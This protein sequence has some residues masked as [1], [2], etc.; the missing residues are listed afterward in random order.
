[1]KKVVKV[2][3][4]RNTFD[5]VSK[6]EPAIW[7]VCHLTNVLRSRKV[8][9]IAHDGIDGFG[10]DQDGLQIVITG[11]SSASKL[12]G[13]SDAGLNVPVEAES[14]GIANTN[15]TLNSVPTVFAVGSDVRGLVYAVLELADIAK[16]AEDPVEA[17]QS[18]QSI[19]EKPT[20]PVRRITRL[21]TS[22][23]E[24]KPWFYDPQF[25]DEYLTEL[26]T[27]RFNQFTFSVG[28]G[29]DY[30]IDRV[31]LDTYFCF[32][33]PFV[34]SVPGYSVEVEGLSADER[35]R[36]LAM[37]RYIGQQA[38]LR[39][40]DFR[41]GLWNHAYDYG[42]NNTNKKYRISGLNA[43]NHAQYCR[44]ALALLLETCPEIEGLTFR[45]HFEGGVPEPTHEF[46][47]VVMEK[48]KDA[49]NLTDLDFHSKGVND[50]LLEITE[51]TG[52]QFM[53]STKYWA[54]HM[55]LPYHQASI[56]RKEFV[57]GT[58]KGKISL[59][60]PSTG[61]HD[62]KARS[63]MSTTSKRSFT[64]YGYADFL[65]GD[66]TYG[67]IHRLWPGTQRIL[68]WGDPAMA[69]GFG[70]FSGFCGSLGVEWFEPL[71]FKG[72]KGSGT[73]GGRELYED[74]ELKLGIRDWTKFLYTYRLWGRL[75]YNPQSHPETWR[76]YLRSNQSFLNF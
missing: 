72:K 41:L 56:R 10:N 51:K 50:E 54:E 64:R 24:D 18:I 32:F 59:H 17:L 42:P 60:P 37:I 75:S 71:S 19:V 55:G 70:R 68:L 9:T 74:E 16:H 15:I 46:W 73:I 29:Y 26:A 3:V 21:F 23:P 27:H 4:F 44:D 58:G 52:K 22:E 11:L 28:A 53:L 48:V 35:E 14:F 25:W 34:L 6:Q 62:G 49:K 1:M 33:Y 67:L 13:W 31:V 30:L 38:K 12:P 47:R 61:H 76:R 57:P 36:N 69:A 65:R 45:V 5:P 43:Q 66:R 63:G 8:E 20:N 39:G 7:A 2:D 40:L